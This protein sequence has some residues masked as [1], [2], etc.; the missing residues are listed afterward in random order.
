M[1]N[2]MRSFTKEE[3]KIYEETLNVDNYKIFR[4]QFLKDLQKNLYWY[5]KLYLN[6]YYIFCKIKFIK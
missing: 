1:K 6:I 5:Q 4:K 2:K 3:S